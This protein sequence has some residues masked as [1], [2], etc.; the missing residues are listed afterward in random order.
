MK[1]M[2]L[3]ITTIHGGSVLDSYC[4]KARQEGVEKQLQINVIPDK[5]SPSGLFKKCRALHEQGFNIFCPTIQEQEE[6]L[7]KISFPLDI[8]PYNSDN[9]RN[10][11]YLFSLSQGNETIISIDDD[12]Y[13]CED[14]KNVYADYSIVAD[15][16]KTQFDVFSAENGWINFCD[17]LYLIN[18]KNY[19]YP[20]G[21]PYHKRHLREKEDYSIHEEID[22][23]KLNVGLWIG[24]PDL[25]AITWLSSPVRVIKA[26]SKSFLMGKNMWAPINTQNTSLHRELMVAY[27][28]VRMGDTI[29]GN[30]ID[31]FGDIFSGYFLQACMKHMG[32]RIRVGTPIAYHRRNLHNYMEDLACEFPGIYITEELTQW[33]CE[34]KLEGST[35]AETYWSLCMALVEQIPKFKGY[36]WTPGTRKFFGKLISYMNEWIEVCKAIG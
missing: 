1:S 20:R 30:V 23:V 21:Y 17:W 18:S 16:N 7:Q 3:V 14:A 19:V 2:S 11:G 15:K 35:Y 4:K 26:A 25:D 9:R 36:I 32:D 8:I 13:C 34:V 10:I 22:R 31:R 5:K 27:Y 33:L 6:F 12:N 28:Y 29:R 24:D